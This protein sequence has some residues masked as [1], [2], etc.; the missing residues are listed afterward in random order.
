MSAS[1]DQPRNARSQRTRGALLAATRQILESDGFEALTMAAVAEQ[2]GVSRRAVY[3]HFT[4]RTE[5]V[6]GLFEYIARQE[7]L[8]EST[9]SI[10]AAPDAVAALR[11]WIK[12]LTTYHPRVMTVDRAI[13]QVR[14]V[15]ADAQRHRDT[16]TQAQLANCRRI[17][18]WLEREG[19]L[20]TSWTVDSATDL[21]FGLICTELFE[22]LMTMRGW[23]T[24]V[25][26][27]RLWTMCR[28]VLVQDRPDRPQQDRPSPASPQVKG[29]PERSPDGI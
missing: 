18:E 7:G 16:V 15:D 14:R 27:N 29:V 25:L 10:W 11:A 2:A 8:A 26:E 6:S 13:E 20:N 3:L 21:L 17:A 5:L 22:R 4:T 9:S 28:A 19:R 1:I 24:E 12:H 23:T